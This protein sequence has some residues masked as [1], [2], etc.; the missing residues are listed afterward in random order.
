MPPTVATAERVTPAGHAHTLGPS[1]DDYHALNAMLNLYDADGKIQFDKDRE[2]AHQYFL[3][4]VN[5]NTVFFHNQ[6]EKLDYLIRENYYEREVLDQYSRNFVKC[7][8]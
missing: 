1:G 4:H 3:Q 8:L 5:Q 7:L 6:D 2:A